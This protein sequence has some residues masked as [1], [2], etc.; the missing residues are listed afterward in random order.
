MMI[1][2]KMCGKNTDGRKHP[3]NN[4]TNK[5]MLLLLYVKYGELNLTVLS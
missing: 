5:N 2:A 3:Y 1:F 4:N